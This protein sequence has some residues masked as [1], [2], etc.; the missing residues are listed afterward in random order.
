MQFEGKWKP[1]MLHWKSEIRGR[2]AALKIEPTRERE[3]VEELSQHL[4]L[5]YE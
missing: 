5:K 2:L 1:T 3:I 4:V